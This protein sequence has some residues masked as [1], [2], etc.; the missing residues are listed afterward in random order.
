MS[1][2]QLIE[3]TP[4]LYSTVLTDPAAANNLVETMGTALAAML[5][6]MP[7]AGKG[8]AITC[9]CDGITPLEFVRTFHLIEGRPSMQTQALTAKFLSRGGKIKVIERSPNAAVVEL[10]SPHADPQTQRFSFTWEEARKE[11][12]VWGKPDKKGHREL[13]PTWATER[14]RTKMLW[15]G[16]LKDAISV[17]DPEVTYGYH[18]EPD[19]QDSQPVS[20]VVAEDPTQVAERPKQDPAEDA[21]FEP[22]KESEA[23]R[24]EKPVDVT[25]DR[26]SR[27][28]AIDF[29]K[30]A[31]TSF[32]KEPHIKTIGDLC[33]LTFEELVGREGMGQGTANK[34]QGLL[35]EHNLTLKESTE[36]TAGGETEETQESRTDATDSQDSDGGL[37][38]EG[39]SGDDQSVASAKHVVAKFAQL[40]DQHGMKD[41][42]VEYMQETCDTSSVHD[43]TLLQASHVYLWVL[44]KV[45]GIAPD[46]LKSV[47]KNAFNVGS[48][49]ALNQDQ[50]NTAIADLEKK[51]SK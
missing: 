43:L 16:V 15:Y 11:S 32:A 20:S 24:E 18:D 19:G 2:T 48:I 28:S 9:L 45:I 41:Q 47:L 25:L 5:G 35:A 29:P 30:R 1:E 10:T 37:F 34:I 50:T 13:K 39:D 31:F 23:S 17:V 4:Q 40:A 3:R 42:T 22:A 36:S 49:P 12:F 8:Y 27:I 7:N 38:S 6:C 51:L 33:D 21:K 44:V 14:G 46:K 26:N